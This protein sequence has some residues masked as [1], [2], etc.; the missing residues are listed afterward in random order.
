MP[1]KKS[2]IS[3]EKIPLTPKTPHKKTLIIHQSAVCEDP[4]LILIKK[5]L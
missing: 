2:C 4:I 5:E 3:E 1:M